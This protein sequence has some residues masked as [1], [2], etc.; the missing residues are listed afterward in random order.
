MSVV[1]RVDIGGCMLAN[2]C[3][4]T[5]ADHCLG[6][7]S[8]PVRYQGLGSKGPT[9][10]GDSVRC[11]ANVAVTGRATIGERCLVGADAA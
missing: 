2:G 11:G 6:D 7:L 10:I 1:D 4:T 5:D 3:F 8:R 9:S